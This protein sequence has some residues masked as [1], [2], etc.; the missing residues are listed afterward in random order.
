MKRL[1]CVFLA[2]VLLC[3]CAPIDEKAQQTVFCMDT[4]MDLQIWGEHA[5]E[6]IAQVMEL[7]YELEDTWS[8]TDA[9]SALNQGTLSGT[10][11]DLLLRAEA[12]CA[13]TDGAFDPKLRSLSMLWGFYDK[14][15][16]V[17]TEEEIFQALA[18]PQWDLG[19]VI[20]GYAGQLAAGEL[21]KLGVERALLNLGGNVQTYGEKSD[22]TPWQVAIQNP[23]GGDYLGV[24]SVYGTK[25]VVTSGDYQRYFEENGVRYHHILDPETGYPADAGLVSVTVICDDGFTADALSTALFV[26]GMEAG[27]AL[28][29]ESSDFEVVFVLPN[30]QVFATEGVALSGCEYEVIYRED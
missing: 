14:E 9:A 29:R 5:E 30:G 24:V 17:P 23:K 28:W 15:Y 19:A 3:G 6:G 20:K 12:M 13:R 16:R 10:E 8:V 26:M 4:V 27:T 25:S 1:I 2:A 21:E 7:L 11:Q 22:G 18:Q